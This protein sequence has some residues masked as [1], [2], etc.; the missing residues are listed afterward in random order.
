MNST[1]W[2]EDGCDSPS[3]QHY[4]PVINQRFRESKV[5]V[6]TTGGLQGKP[7]NKVLSSSDERQCEKIAG[8]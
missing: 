6:C 8:F 7:P 1:R 5:Q 3:K 2:N 4:N